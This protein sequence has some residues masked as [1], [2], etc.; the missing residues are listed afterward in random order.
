MR[1]H[2]RPTSVSQPLTLLPLS[3]N[4]RHLWPPS[5]RCYSLLS[6]ASCGVC[7]LAPNRYV[8]KKS[9]HWWS[10][11][12][13]CDWCCGRFVGEIP[14]TPQKNSP[15]LL[16]PKGQQTYS[17][18]VSRQAFPLSFQGGSKGELR[19]GSPRDGLEVT[20]ETVT[21]GVSG[22]GGLRT[23]GGPM[24]RSHPSGQGQHLGEA[25]EGP[26]PQV[27]LFPEKHSW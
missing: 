8:V 15:Y 1:Y 9:E 2:F 25:V 16:L 26:E 17:L 11:P 13:E 20:F 27:S 12:L 10:E 14:C 24:D 7:N 18:Y 22:A 19:R 23:P 21:L 5:L 3:R 4:P 6:L